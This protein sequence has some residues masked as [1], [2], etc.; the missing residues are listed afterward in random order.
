MAGDDITFSGWIALIALVLT[1]VGWAGGWAFA[2]GR[3]AQSAEDNHGQIGHIHDALAE[4]ERRVDAL[5]ERVARIE[6]RVDHLSDSIKRADTALN[7]LA[8]KMEALSK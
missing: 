7:K 5:G 2:R 8:D 6:A 1:G 4:K 3:N